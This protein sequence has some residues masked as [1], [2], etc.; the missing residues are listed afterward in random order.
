[1][2]HAIPVKLHGE[3]FGAHVLKIFVLEFFRW[4]LS[5]RRTCSSL[6]YV[7]RHKEKR[8]R[9]ENVGRRRFRWPENG[10]EDIPAGGGGGG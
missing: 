1:M 5:C 8:Q 6:E 9:R 4:A 2:L 3:L 7:G 10:G